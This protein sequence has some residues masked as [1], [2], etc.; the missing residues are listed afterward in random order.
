MSPTRGG[1]I[2]IEAVSDQRAREDFIR[3]PWSIFADDPHWVAPLLMERRDVIAPKQPVFAHLDWQA[4][5]AYRGDKPVGRISA[6]IDRLHL[7]RYNDGTGFFGFLDGIEDPSVFAALFEAGEAW[8]AERGMTR[9][10]GP[11]SLN[12]KQ[13]VGLLVDGFDS[14]PYIMMGHAHPHYGRMVEAL[15]YAKIMDLHAYLISSGFQPPKIMVSLCQRLR[16]RIT[17]RPLRR[18]QAREDFAIM[19]DIFNDAWSENWGFV[20]FSEDEFQAIAHELLMLLPDDFVQIAEIDGEPVS[21]I[22][23]LPN[24]NEAIADLD[25]RLLPLGWAKLLWRLKVRYPRTA[26]I[27]LMGVRKKFQH[28]RFGPGLALSVVD[29]LR[30]PALSRGLEWVEM[31]WILENNQPMRNIIDIL[32]GRRT[33]CYRIYDKALS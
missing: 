16:K 5:I 17:I 26:R 30:A 4:W 18:K 15:G 32:G 29:A 31:S 33:K 3:V 1:P 23:L 14:P 20:P 10:R 13:E 6:Q 12:I 24:V 22:V 9:V 28:T 25:G 21:F 27:P 19:R 11:F 2:R 8:L 7:E